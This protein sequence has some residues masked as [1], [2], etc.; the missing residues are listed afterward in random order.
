MSTTWTYQSTL[1]STAANT[2]NT[3]IV[4]RMVGD[5]LINDQQLQDAEVN[6]AISVYSNLY[7]AAAECARWISAQYSRKVDT[8]T[9]EVRTLY[10]TQQRAYAQR[11]IE[12]EQR[13][14]SRGAGALPYAGG[15]SIADKAAQLDDTDRVTPQFNIGMDDN[16]LPVGVG[17]GNETPGNP[18]GGNSESGSGG[19]GNAP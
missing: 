10:S 6:Y 12:L 5:V 14:M 7:L 15:I 13:G 17:S 3:A 19:S 2:S 4:R 18:A 11:A 9:G 8:V 1:L 16:L